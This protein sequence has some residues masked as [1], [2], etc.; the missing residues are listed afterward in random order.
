MVDYGFAQLDDNG[1]VI[2]DTFTPTLPQNGEWVR[3]FRVP[4]TCGNICGRTIYSRLDGECYFEQEYTYTDTGDVTIYY[5]HGTVPTK[6]AFYKNGTL[7]SSTN[8]VGLNSYQ[9]LL[10]TYTDSCSLAQEAIEPLPIDGSY[11]ISVV[12]TDVIKVRVY[13]PKPSISDYDFSV[14]CVNNAVD[15][16]VSAWSAWSAWTSNGDGTESRT[17]TRTI[18]T[19]PSG[20]GTACPPLSETETRTAIAA[21]LSFVTDAT[22]TS[23][24]Y[25]SATVTDII[26]SDVFSVLPSTP[27]TRTGTFTTDN[28]NFTLS[29]EINSGSSFTQAN[30]S[31]RNGGITLY[32]A[33]VTI[34]P[35]QSFD[36]GASIVIPI[37]NSITL[38]IK[39]SP[40][41]T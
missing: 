30:F 1:N 36:I 3:V 28:I 2:W 9:T 25:L 5:N 38:T 7:L 6:F 26:T 13:N 34:D 31:I 20:G 37:Q 14:T 24:E 39:L 27:V 4:C 29:G 17:R 10:D 19:A 22:V 8:Y 35:T 15:C 32:S 11:L 23:I 18:L 33:V 40:I 41:L 21:T 12:P 16:V